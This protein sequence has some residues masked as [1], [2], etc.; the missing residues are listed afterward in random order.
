ME[1]NRV[2]K[3]QACSHDFNKRKPCCCGVFLK[4]GITGLVF[5]EKGLLGFC[6]MDLDKKIA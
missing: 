2:N 1:S 4:G 3:L 6:L 5:T